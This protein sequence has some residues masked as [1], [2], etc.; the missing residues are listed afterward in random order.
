MKQKT[1]HMLPS[2][3]KK[4]CLNKKQDFV[5]H[6]NVAAA[7]TEQRESGLPLY[8]GLKVH[9]I[10]TQAMKNPTAVHD[11]VHDVLE[12]LN[13]DFGEMKAE[14]A[15][16]SELYFN[17]YKLLQVPANQRTY[18]EYL[19]KAGDANVEFLL[20]GEPKLYSLT[21]YDK[22][23]DDLAY[24]DTLLKKQVAPAIEPHKYLNL[25]ICLGIDSPFLG[26]AQFPKVK[27]TAEEIRTDGVVFFVTVFPFHLYKTV[28]HEVGHW[29]GLNHLFQKEG[30]DY[31][32]D[33]DDTPY[34]R[35]PTYG[36]PL[37]ESTWPMS[38]E[39]NG[40]VSKHLFM[41]YMDYTDDL[42]MSMFTKGQVKKLRGV[43]QSV[44]K[45]YLL[46]DTEVKKW[47]PTQHIPT[48]DVETTP[49]TTPAQPVAAPTPAQP[50]APPTQVPSA[51]NS[52]QGPAV[53][54]SPQ[55]HATTIAQTELP[56]TASK[57]PPSQFHPDPSP[58]SPASPVLP[59]IISPI[60]EAVQSVDY[61]PKWEAE[62]KPILD[63]MQKQREADPVAPLRAEHIEISY[64][65]HLFSFFHLCTC[66]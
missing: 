3:Q 30:D 59:P 47:K 13:Q 31:S 18:L 63:Q 46:S 15:I 64:F 49:L 60:S 44:R 53:G 26:Y 48:T 40:R 54:P 34:Q 50:V 7:R 38:K 42:R 2:R 12:S 43:L 17:K 65:A 58:S 45:D 66:H 62:W 55:V 24:W 29:C 61:P 41:N 32:D 51:P 1:P 8:I 4:R 22:T 39:R 10:S 36:D 25:W 57:P 27:R 9:V 19:E 16:H 28:T 37:N 21:N 35:E 52:T 11:Y 5:D 6:L 23:N 33:V 14:T 56:S 20:T